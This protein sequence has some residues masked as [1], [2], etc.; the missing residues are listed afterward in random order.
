MSAQPKPSEA[1]R[2]TTSSF[3]QVHAQE[4]RRANHADQHS[5]RSMHSVTL[6]GSRARTMQSENLQKG[7]GVH[8]YYHIDLHA[9]RHPA[10]GL[11][12]GSL[13]V[14]ARVVVRG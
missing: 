13:R 3:L 11:K 2:I 6:H 9:W 14:A 5:V 10:S 1:Q 12:V 4:S 8:N 7:C